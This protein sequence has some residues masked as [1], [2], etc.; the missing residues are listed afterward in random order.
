MENNLL[1]KIKNRWLKF[2]LEKGHLITVGERHR[3]IGK[4]TMMID[5]AKKKNYGIVVGNQP[6]AEM[7]MKHE[8]LR[9]YRLAENFTIDFKDREDEVL[10]D[11]SVQPSMI[12]RLQ[13]EFPDIKIRGGFIQ[14]YKFEI[15]K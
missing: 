15:K 13:K 3:R 4:T 6:T 1:S 11:E 12:K 10:I 2:R 7:L 14:S 9:I 8:D 5:L